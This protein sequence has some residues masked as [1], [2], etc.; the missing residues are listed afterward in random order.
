MTALW[1]LAALGLQL[2]TWQ[3]QGCT[4]PARQSR[5][6]D[7]ARQQSRPKGP[8]H[9]CR[10]R[11]PGRGLQAVH[12]IEA[13]RGTKLTVMPE[14][15][16][17]VG[18]VM[19]LRLLEH[20]SA[21]SVSANMFVKEEKCASLYGE[22][23]LSLPQQPGGA[24]I[25]GRDRTVGTTGRGRLGAGGGALAK[26]LEKLSPGPDPDEGEGKTQ[27]GWG[28][29]WPPDAHGLP[30]SNPARVRLAARGSMVARGG[31]SKASAASAGRPR[32]A[33]AGLS[34]VFTAP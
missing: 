23:A 11:E 34:C 29:S 20:F 10:M 6:T 2:K 28:P 8:E 3:E 5:A 9:A 22:A 27:Q 24:A 7:P 18:R 26:Y 4:D 21:H 1:G 14:A 19:S 30:P 16:H 17:Q 13:H 12:C 31:Q 15:A 32:P 33:W 25:C